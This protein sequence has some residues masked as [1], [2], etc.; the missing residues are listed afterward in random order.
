[1]IRERILDI[2][3]PGYKLIKSILESYSDYELNLAINDISEIDTF[4]E[5]VIK[6]IQY[7]IGPDLIEFIITGD[8][9][10]DESDFIRDYCCNAIFIERN[11]DNKSYE[12]NKQK[13]INMCEEI[14]LELGKDCYQI[15]KDIDFGDLILRL[16]KYYPLKFVE[17]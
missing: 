15:N 2:L 9:T 17:V 5:D 12:I 10:Y 8:I 4:R 1:M 11:S 13:V 7:T 6:A 16:N 14:I 3:F